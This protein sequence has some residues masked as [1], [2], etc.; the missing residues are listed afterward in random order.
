MTAAQRRRR[1][2]PLPPAGPERVQPPSPS[3]SGGVQSHGTARKNGVV[4]STAGAARAS[5]TVSPAVTFWS[6]CDPSILAQVYRS[7]STLAPS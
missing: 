5:V 1:H 7:S 6:T 2:D 3:T 4:A